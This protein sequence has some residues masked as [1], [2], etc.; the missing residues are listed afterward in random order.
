MPR[1][2]EHSLCVKCLGETHVPA[3]CL[4]CTNLKTRACR[5]RDLRLKMLLMEK[6]LQPPME[7][8]RKPAES[9]QL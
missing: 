1:S 6:A 4:H 8:G 3:K 5:D 9:R 2:D 7:K